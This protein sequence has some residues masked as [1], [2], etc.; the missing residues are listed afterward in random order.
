MEQKQAKAAFSINILILRLYVHGDW[1]ALKL[2]QNTEYPVAMC[3]FRVFF[4]YITLHNITRNLLPK[5]PFDTLIG[6]TALF[7]K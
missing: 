7:F 1:Y 6:C 3:I 4:S 5:K 2:T